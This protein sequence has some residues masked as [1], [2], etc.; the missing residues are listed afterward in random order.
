MLKTKDRTRLNNKDRRDVFAKP[1]NAGDYL[2]MCHLVTGWNRETSLYFPDQGTRR[3]EAGSFSEVSL[4]ALAD[5]EAARRQAVA[6][7][8]AEGAKKEVEVERVEMR[9]I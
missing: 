8:E 4:K 7:N 5:H 3:V 1:E 2:L 9:R 6:D